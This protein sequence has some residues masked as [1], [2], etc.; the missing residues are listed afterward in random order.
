MFC[1]GYGCK[2]IHPTVHVMSHTCCVPPKWVVEEYMPPSDWLII[3]YLL[4]YFT[5]IYL[6]KI[7]Y[8]L[9]LP[10][11]SFC[12]IFWIFIHRQPPNSHGQN[13]NTRPEKRT[14]VPIQHTHAHV[15]SCA[16]LYASGTTATD[17]T[18]YIVSGYNFFPSN[19]VS[20]EVLTDAIKDFSPIE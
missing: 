16:F 12:R 6:Y 5:S 19:I 10:V 2:S 9:L 18:V 3:I 7:Y 20:C 15:C 4:I 8:V 17:Q 14:H 11:T 1:K 13:R